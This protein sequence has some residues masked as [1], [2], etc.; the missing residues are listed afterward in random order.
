MT[1]VRKGFAATILSAAALGAFVFGGNIVKDVQ[2]AR[3]QEQVQATREQLQ[4]LQDFAGVYRAVGKA[5]EPSVVSIR[6]HKF[7]KGVKHAQMPFDDDMLKRFFPDNDGDGQP[8]VPDNLRNRLNGGDDTDME[9]IGTGSGAI[10]QVDGST[11]YIVTN[12]HVAGGAD[13]MTVT[14]YDGRQIT[15]AKTVGTDPKSDLAVVKIE[16]DRLIPAKW[17]DSDQLAKGDIVMAFGSPFGY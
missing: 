7:V 1:R 2:F 9:Q 11:A 4:T 5:V 17:G 6:V 10:M 12:N 15:K 14:L 13:E 16:A 8:D 3:A